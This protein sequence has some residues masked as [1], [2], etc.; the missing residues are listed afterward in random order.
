MTVEVTDVGA[1]L[2]T[3][4]QATGDTLSSTKLT[5]LPGKI[6]TGFTDVV[7]RGDLTGPRIGTCAYG[8]PALGEFGSAGVGTERAPGFFNFDSSIGMRF[9]I[10]ERQRIEF[11]AELFNILNSVSFGPPG[12][13]IAAPASYGA[14]G[15]QINSPRNIQ[16]SLKYAF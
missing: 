16:F 5:S 7:A 8:V 4:T 2:Q 10:T 11:R 14:I 6:S 12:R 13:D 3:E 1:L 15:S 9:N